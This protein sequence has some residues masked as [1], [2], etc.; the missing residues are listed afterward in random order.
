MNQLKRVG[1]NTIILNDLIQAITFFSRLKGLQFKRLLAPGQG[2][3]ISPCDSIH[4]LFMRFPIDAV[5]VDKDFKIVKIIKNLKPWTG[6]V[7]P[8]K[9]AFSVIEINAGLS[10]KAGLTIGDQLSI[11]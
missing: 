11:I 7:F 2:L 1:D 10:D 3:L 4:M 9:G 8:V 5:F 6:F